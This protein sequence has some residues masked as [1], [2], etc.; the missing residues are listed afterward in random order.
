MPANFQPDMRVTEIAEAY[1]LDAIDLAASNFG[2]TLD[3][4]EASVRKVEEMLGRLHDEMANAQPREDAIWTFAK[5]FGSY[6]GEVL[7]RHH[8]GEWGM[9]DMDGQSFPGIQQKN[10]ALCWPWSK[11]QKRL[12]NGPEDNVWHY[13]TVLV[14]DA[15]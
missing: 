14:Q 13:Y 7:R 11:A 6:V 15:A 5:A 4:S 3:W 12:V 1:S 8:S 10:G 2:V 9:L